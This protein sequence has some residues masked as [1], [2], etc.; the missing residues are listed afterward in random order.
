MYTQAQTEEK[1]L[2]NS[3]YIQEY[4]FTE[5]Y[6]EYFT[7][8]YNYVYYRVNNYH[9]TDDLTSLIFVKLFEKRNYYCADKA[10]IFAWV[11]GI[12][13]NT[14]T[15]Y[16]RQ[17]GRNTYVCLEATEELID[18]GLSPDDIAVSNEIRRYLHKALNSLSDRER[19]I[20]ALKF[21]S[22]FTNREIAKLIGLSESNTGVTLFRAMRRLRYIMEIQGVNID[23]GEY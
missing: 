21:W 9:D 7:R 2:S 6:N 17:Q 10:P 13:R 11:F 19:D 8:V 12:A 3:A 5:F 1:G 23:D 20:I 4:N 22:G 16:F 18:L 14:V 15:D